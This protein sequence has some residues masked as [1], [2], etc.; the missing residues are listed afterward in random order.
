MDLFFPL[1]TASLV[2]TV[3][4]LYYLDKSPRDYYN[5]QHNLPFPKSDLYSNGSVSVKGRNNIDLVHDGTNST[6]CSTFDFERSFFPT[7]RHSLPPLL[8]SFPGS[9]NTWSRLIIDFAG[10]IYSGS[11]YYDSDLVKILPG[12]KFCSKR[13][14][15]IKAHPNIQSYKILSS[16]QLPDKCTK[17]GI[18]VFDR[19][20]F[21]VRNPYES[22]WSEFQRR[23]SGKHAGELFEE[24]LSKR[25]LFV[26]VHK[27]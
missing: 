18:K 1:L 22:I 17:D 9:G 21:L 24:K 16:Q 12:E 14:S 15:I 23:R 19:A 26:Q 6:G 10:G 3:I 2:F 13:V 4:C 27:K 5:L 8:Y 25:F 20:V 7:N 11:V